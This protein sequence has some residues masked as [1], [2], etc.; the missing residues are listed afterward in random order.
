MFGVLARLFLYFSLS[1][2]LVNDL[3][4]C[5]IPL[6][7]YG[8][9]LKLPEKWLPLLSR[10]KAYTCNMKLGNP[11]RMSVVEWPST[12][13]HPCMIPSSLNVGKIFEYAEV[14]FLPLY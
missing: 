6:A 7:V 13:L 12:T 1:S 5:L 2:N 8:P 3:S 10:D 11:K 14:F 9:G 4:L